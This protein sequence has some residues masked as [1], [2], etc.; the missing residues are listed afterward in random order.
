[1]AQVDSSN[2]PN[3]PGNPN[4]APGNV[5]PPGQ[6]QTNQ[7]ATS[8]GAG[9]V[10]TTGSGNVTGQVVGTNNPSQPFN[11][12]SAYLAANAPASADLAGK[13][14]GNISGA[15]DQAKNDIGAASQTFTDSVNQGYVPENQGV[16]S[17][18]ASNPVAA[19]ANPDTISAFQSQL[20]DVYK[21]PTDFTTVP[22]YSNFQSEVANAQGVGQLVKTPE[23]IQ[24]LLKNVEGPTTQ[25][26]NNLDSI[27][28]NLDPSNV[29][30]I[31]NAG[32]AAN[33][34]NNALGDFLQTTT[35]N[36]NALAQTGLT[37]AQQV[38]QMAQNILNTQVTNLSSQITDAVANAEQI[39]GKNNVYSS[40]ITA[41]N[42]G[43]PI[44]A[45]Q[46]A[47]I[48]IDPA[49]YNKQLSIAQNASTIYGPSGNGAKYV[50]NTQI[51][52]NL[53]SY[54]KSGS[55]L[56]GAVP[57]AATVSTP[58]QYALADALSKLSGQELGLPINQST[59]SD[60]STFIP[61][62]VAPSFDLSGA[63]SGLKN[64]F[65]GNDLKQF[66]AFDPGPLAPVP[67]I[68]AWPQSVLSL[69]DRIWQAGLPGLYQHTPHG[70]EGFGSNPNIY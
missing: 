41:I 16:I 54:L 7:P 22:G 32:A 18:V 21:G 42:D 63:T 67:G 66:Q 29:K 27:L 43:L 11:N 69:A 45:E 62:L 51:P 59:A 30:T 70:G 10:T 8:G 40:I 31:Q 68:G 26:I 48:G 2:N 20:N 17:A 28:L 57:S 55:L 3:D 6:G 65:Y 53:A 44:S 13:I 50:A 23:G 52:A 56:T 36:N 1:M 37:S 46:G 15:A 64:A 19:A 5:N 38:Q 25:G 58:Q 39:Y 4:N 34:D 61:D 49:A 24:T 35:T 33:S 47:A 60:A 14:A 9:A 12:I